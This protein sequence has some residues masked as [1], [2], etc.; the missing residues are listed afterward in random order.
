MRYAELRQMKRHWYEHQIVWIGGT[1]IA[2]TFGLL[3][4]LG[5]M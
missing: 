1:F 5:L 2:V 3:R 4:M